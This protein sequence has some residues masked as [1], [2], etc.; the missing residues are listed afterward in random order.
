MRSVGSTLPVVRSIMLGVGLATQPRIGVIELVGVRLAGIDREGVA[1]G[2]AHIGHVGQQAPRQLALHA[3]APGVHR[4][5]PRLLLDGGASQ[6]VLERRRIEAVVDRRPLQAHRPADDPGEAAIL[7]VAQPVVARAEAAADRGLAVAENVPAEPETRR[8]LD[9]RAGE[10]VGE[11]LAEHGAVVDVARPGDDGADPRDWAAV[12]PVSGLTRHAIG[13]G[14]GEHAVGAVRLPQLD[15]LGRIP[16]GGIEPADVATALVDD[17]DV[18]EAH[19]EIERDLPV[20]APVVLDE[21]LRLVERAA[22]SGCCCCSRC[23]C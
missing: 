17:A 5:G 14:A 4:D 23:R 12:S 3:N 2:I 16:G 10:R 8:G 11:F 18:R 7:A 19:A 1:H 13:A 22:S 9:P 6:R 20:Q 21:E 15:R